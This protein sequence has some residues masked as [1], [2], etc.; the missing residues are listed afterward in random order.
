MPLPPDE[1]RQRILNSPV[2]SPEENRRLYEKYFTAPMRTVQVLNKLYALDQKRVLVLA[3]AYGYEVVHFGQGSVGLD[4][5]PQFCAFGRSLGLDL[6]EADLE[7]ALPQFDEPFQAVFCSNFIEHVMAPHVLLARI[8]RLLAPDGLLCFKVPVTPAP[9]VHRLYR[10]LGK[11]H[12][13]D[14]PDHINFFSPRTAAWTAIFAGYKVLGL[15]SPLL[16]GQALTR[17][18][19]PLLRPLLPSV[20]VV[21]QKDPTFRPAERRIP[22]YNW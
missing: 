13:F 15:H 6:R 20:V 8:H 19:T 7:A 17:P 3:C 2:F 11:D 12:G 10:A 4:I 22:F 1:L 9:W 5:D 16:D 14:F 18:L 21:A